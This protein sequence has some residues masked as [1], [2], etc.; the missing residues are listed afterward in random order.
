M[1]P[2]E[3]ISA[4]EAVLRQGREALDRLSA[5]LED[6]AALRPDCAPWMRIT[7]ARTG[8]GTWRWTRRGSFPPICLAAYSRRT[9]FITC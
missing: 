9:G 1:R 2:I 5:A 4:M 3:R 7:A 8:A 6:Y